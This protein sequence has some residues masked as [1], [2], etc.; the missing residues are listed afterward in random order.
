M[1]YVYSPWIFEDIRKWDSLVK[2]EYLVN[3]K[4][5]VVI[6]EQEDEIEYVYILKKGRV[7]L[8][9][10]APDG[11]EHVMLFVLPGGIF[12]EAE[13]IEERQSFFR[14]ETLSEVSLYKL[15][16]SVVL[17]AMKD[18]ELCILMM[19]NM[20][21]KLSL[22]ETEFISMSVDDTK[23]RVARTLLCAADT[24]GAM[25]EG[26]RRI[27]LTITQQD[28]ANLV[29]STRLTVGNILREFIGRGLIKKERNHFYILDKEGLERELIK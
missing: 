20:M 19:K 8:L 24:F 2:K 12:G 18:R 3:I 29:N 16:K 22:I 28:I 9:Y 11:T 6:Y 23:T 14:A 17:A 1:K 27:E 25:D 26:F 15:P 21:K 10:I 13:C 5:R 4:K 7:R